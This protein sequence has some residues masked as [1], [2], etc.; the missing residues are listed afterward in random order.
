M[1]A[2]ILRGSATQTLRLGVYSHLVAANDWGYPLSFTSSLSAGLFGYDD[3]FYYRAAGVEVGGQRDALFAGGW[4]LEWRLFAERQRAATERVEKSLTGV[5][6]YVNGF[7]KQHGVTDDKIVGGLKE[8]V[9]GIEG[10]LD[11]VSAFLDMTVN[12]YEHTGTQ[13]V[14]RSLISRAASEI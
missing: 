14:A 3:G 8:H 6:G 7:V 11:Y 10:K 1:E 9:D 2:S 12:Y 5:R 4:H 13:T